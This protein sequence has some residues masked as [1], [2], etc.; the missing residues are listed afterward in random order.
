MDKSIETLEADIN[1]VLKTGE[2][3]TKEISK[4][5]ADDIAKSLSRQFTRSKGERARTLRVSNLGTPCERKLWYHVNSNI[6]PE[7]L[8]A[9][10]LNKFIFGDI[11]ES[12]I[13]GLCKAA[14]HDVVGMQDSVDVHGIKGSRD[15]V[16]DGMLIDVKS[17]SSRA[18]EKFKRNGL[19]SDDPFG[20]L[21]QLSSYLYG[22]RSDPLVK[23]KTKAGFLAFDKQ[24]GHIAL[25]IYDFTEEVES[26]GDEVE[27]KKTLVS[28]A[29]PPDK[30]YEPVPHGKGGNM[31]LPMM[32]SYCDFKYQCWDNLKEYIYSNGPIY[33]THVEKTPNVPMKGGENF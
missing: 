30:T 16:I 20:Y 25:D 17:A 24:F 7:P 18:F 27:R 32:C 31:K 28:K 13:L 33:L 26:K 5:V 2:G 11:T 29:Y 9:S 6:A 4:W 15:C 14:G 3:W 12:Y 8:L 23:D 19:R 22:S 21:S 1:H 10:T